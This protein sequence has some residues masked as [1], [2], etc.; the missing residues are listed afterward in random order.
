MA[1]SKINKAI[2]VSL[3][4]I[5]TFQLTACGTIFYPERKGQKG[6]SIDPVV[7]IA[8]AVGLLFWFI[9]GVIAFAVDF[10]TG[11]I[12]SSRGKHSSLTPEELKSVTQ[13]DGKV[14]TQALNEIL[15][16]KFGEP[17]NLNASNVQIKKFA[18]KDALL[19]YFAKTQMQV[20][21]L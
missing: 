10:T 20:A 4:M 5:L 6:G 3:A 11:A 17:I 7:A 13:E 18:S 15:S 1:V 16:K 21:G 14:N 2:G 12:Y 19:A 8:D 9:P